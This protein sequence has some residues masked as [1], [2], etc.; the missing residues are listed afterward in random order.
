MG[1]LGLAQAMG[2]V[3]SG[4]YNIPIKYIISKDRSRADL[5]LQIINNTLERPC[6]NRL[7]RTSRL[8]GG[9]EQT[10]SSG[11]SCNG[12]GRLGSVRTA[13]SSEG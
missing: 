6:S 11:D 8:T 9:G 10:M 1:S 5:I 2:Q 13:N 7:D 3:C 4:R 12:G